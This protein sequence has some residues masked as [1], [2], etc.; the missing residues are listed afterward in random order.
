[1][2]GVLP[3]FAFTYQSGVIVHLRTF[4]LNITKPIKKVRKILKKV[5]Y[6]Y[7]YEKSKKK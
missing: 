1:M 2:G 4:E 3:F 6:L 5:C 7:I